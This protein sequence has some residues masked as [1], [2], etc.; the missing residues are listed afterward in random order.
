MKDASAKLPFVII[1]ILMLLVSSV[2]MLMNT[3]PVPLRNYDVLGIGE[4]KEVEGE[5]TGVDETSQ[6]QWSDAV[7]FGQEEF[8]GEIQYD[9]GEMFAS[10]QNMSTADT[11]VTPEENILE[12]GKE[13]MRTFVNGQTQDKVEFFTTDAESDYRISIK[14]NVS[15]SPINGEMSV[16]LY[17]ERGVKVADSSGFLP[18]YGNTSNY[19]DEFIVDFVLEKSKKYTIKVDGKNIAG[20][21]EVSVLERR[22]DAGHSK[23]VATPIRVGDEITATIN[24]TKSDWFVCNIEE[25]GTYEATIYNVDV[26]ER[27]YITAKYDDASLF[28]SNAKNEDDYT[29]RFSIHRA[30]NVYIEICS[31]STSASGTYILT[32]KKID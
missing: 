1:L 9:G 29:G 19:R 2:V 4:L 23:D 6:N 28:H 17:D 15:E 8:A 30:G 20:D 12:L 26:G 24:S 14:T 16:T 5:N 3:A 7:T 31:T 18:Q 11:F 10:E 32:I 21:Y 27:V 25:L 13:Y 22:R